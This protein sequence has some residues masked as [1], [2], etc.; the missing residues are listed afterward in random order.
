MKY[1]LL[2]IFFTSLSFGYSQTQN[3]WDKRTTFLGGKRERAIAFAINGFG[4]VGTGVDTAEMTHNDLW[5]YD[6]A[7]LVWSQKASIPGST[8]RNAVAVVI[9]DKAYVGMGADSATSWAGTILS[10]WWEYDPSSNSWLQKA[11]YPGGWGYEGT[12]STATYLGPGMYFGTGFEANGKAYVCGGKMGPDQYGHDLWEYNPTTDSWT[13]KAD[14]PGLDRYQLSSF[15]IDNYGYVGMGIDHDLYRKDWWKYDPIA[16]NWTEVASL[17]GVERGGASTFVIGQRGFVVFG[18]DG[19]FKDE[20]WE[21]NPFTDSWMIRANFPGGERKNAIAFA[22]DDSAYAGI[23]KGASGKRRNFYRYYPLF[24]VG[25]E[26]NQQ[27][28]KLY[29]NPTTDYIHL[30]LENAANYQFQLVDLQGKEMLTTANTTID[31]Q[32]ISQGMYI[33]NVFDSN[34]KHLKSEKVLIQ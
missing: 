19:G 29:P 15:S 22:I 34:G 8:R 7:T 23:G 5:E 1:L 27:I 25:I 9:D 10:D 4:Y 6:P 30:E 2:T 31:V 18:T 26:E 33:L 3:D 24:P 13:R 20:L 17:P 32:D 12:S 21:Y 14:F 28:I 16:D 11:D